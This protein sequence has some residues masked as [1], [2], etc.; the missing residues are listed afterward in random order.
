MTPLQKKIEG[1]AEQIQHL[2]QVATRQEAAIAQ[3][4][5]V[6]NVNAQATDAAQ[7]A[8]QNMIIW[9]SEEMGEDAVVRLRKQLG[10]TDEQVEEANG[11]SIIQLD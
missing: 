1:L 8:I 3:I 6:V 2:A 9:L 4:T 5:D 10:I 11:G 7:T